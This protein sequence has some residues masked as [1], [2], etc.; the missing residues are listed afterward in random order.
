MIDNP[1]K[2]LEEALD[3]LLDDLKD[4]DKKTIADCKTKESMIGMCHHGFG[5]WIR[6]NFGLWD[7]N[8]ELVK[9]LEQYSTRGGFTCKGD[10]ASEVILDKLW[11]RLRENE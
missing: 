9:D 11:E 5:T 10:D 8:D 1:P 2:T 4:E 6:N 3:Y 7:G